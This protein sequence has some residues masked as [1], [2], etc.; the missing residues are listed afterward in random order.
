MKRALIGV[1][2]ALAASVGIGTNSA[3]AGEPGGN[4][5]ITYYFGADVG[6][7]TAA[8][9]AVPEIFQG[10]LNVTAANCPAPSVS[11]GPGGWQTTLSCSLA[12]G[13]YTVGIDGLT[14]RGVRSVGCQDTSNG[15]EEIDADGADFPILFNSVVCDVFI[16]PYP[17]LYIDKNVV[18][19]VATSSDFGLEV[20]DT[21]GGTATS[22]LTDPS[23]T[24]CDSTG[25][26][27]TDCAAIQLEPGTYYLG[28]T[29]VAGYL[30]QSLLC[31]PVGGLD[32]EQLP[33]PQFSGVELSLGSGDVLCT[34]TNEYFT[35]T[36]TVD[37]DVV[38]DEGGTAD[39]SAFTIEVYDASN[40]LVA[41]GVDPEPGTG[42]ASLSFVLPI[43][44]YT[45]GVDG[46]AGYSS[47]VVV[48][49]EELPRA[50][51]DDPS[52][53]FTLGRFTTASAVITANDPAP[54]VT[55]TTVPPSTVDPNAV[56]PA[57]GT[58]SSTILMWALAAFF[59]G[60]GTVLV[61]RRP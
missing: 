42:N 36:V 54:L 45:F 59:L 39:G 38:N 25:P 12:N 27:G 24:A 26:N 58:A 5:A 3:T 32:G 51:I 28:E 50:Q 48:V 31:T 22:T 7:E 40:T 23:G 37:I 56:L 9:A 8:N 41:S 34:L 35:Q 33:T 49:E 4:V 60:S 55:T 61:T 18:N 1:M 17:T 29:S 20:F 14:N 6:A 15:V 47:S 16:E 53:Q 30:P 19:G 10:G 2:V 46:P 43:G 44:S 13:D 21:D 52:A 11:V 57:T